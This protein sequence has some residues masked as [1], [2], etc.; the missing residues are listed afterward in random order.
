MSP[1]S[2]SILVN[3]FPRKQLPTAIGIWAG[4]SGL[5]LAAGPLI[6]GWLVES[7]SWSAVFWINVP[8]GIVAFAITFVVGGR[9]ARPAHHEARPRR[10]VAD[11][12][13]P[14]LPGVGADRD[15]RPL[16]DVGTHRPWLVAAGVLLDAF[17]FWELRAEPDAAA[18]VLP[19]RA[20][21]ASTS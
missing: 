19:P 10:H 9:V 1:L 7:V 11:H 12:R 14:V 13:G 17:V 16:L 2:L 21:A 20:F 5:G 6:G 18:L 8:I 4:I 3:A 15:E